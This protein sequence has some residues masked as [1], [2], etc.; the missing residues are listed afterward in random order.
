MESLVGGAGLLS[1]EGRRWKYS[2][3]T[4]WSDAATQL[5]H[6]KSNRLAESHPKLKPVVRQHLQE[7]VLPLSGLGPLQSVSENLS[8]HLQTTQLVICSHLPG[9]MRFPWGDPSESLNDRG[10]MGGVHNKVAIGSMLFLPHNFQQYPISIKCTY[11]LGPEKEGFGQDLLTY[12]LP[13]GPPRHSFQC[14]RERGDF[15]QRVITM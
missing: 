6:C 7:S 14:E 1:F 4:P 3:W 13:P 15:T 2:V 8:Q 10:V 12:H 5:K 9:R 11:H